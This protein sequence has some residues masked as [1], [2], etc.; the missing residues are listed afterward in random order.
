L[1]RVEVMEVDV[2]GVLVDVDAVLTVR[3]WERE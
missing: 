1:L 2:L 3:E